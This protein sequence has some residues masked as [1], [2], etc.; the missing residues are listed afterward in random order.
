MCIRDSLTIGL[1]A[2][3]QWSVVTGPVQQA[4]FFLNVDRQFDAFAKGLIDTSNFVYFL[5]GTGL[6]LFLAVVFLQSKR[7][8]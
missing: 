1:Y 8:R 6:F 3:P 2:L 4:M 5:S 7:W